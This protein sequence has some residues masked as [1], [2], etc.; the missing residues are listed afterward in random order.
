MNFVHIQ[1]AQKL[2]GATNVFLRSRRE[3]EGGGGLIAYY[4]DWNVSSPLELIKA[5]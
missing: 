3:G 5:R 4:S 2:L 1:N